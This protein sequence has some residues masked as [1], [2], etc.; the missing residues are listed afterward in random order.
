M[1][2]CFFPDLHSTK[3]HSKLWKP[4]LLMSCLGLMIKLQQMASQIQIQVFHYQAILTL[5]SI[6]FHFSPQCEENATP[7]ETKIF[8][9]KERES[10]LLGDKARFPTFNFCQEVLSSQNYTVQ[11][12]LKAAGRNILRCRNSSEQFLKC[13]ALSGKWKNNG[14]HLSL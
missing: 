4:L 11:S 5:N 8:E 3:T 9:G 7:A 2:I 12:N 14:T 13:K 10:C 6:V 1:F